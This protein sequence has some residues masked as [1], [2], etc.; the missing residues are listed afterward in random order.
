VQRRR[1]RP[2][3]PE[4]TPTRDAKAPER[5]LSR[6]ADPQAPALPENAGASSES[7]G[8]LSGP[9]PAQATVPVPEVAETEEADVTPTYPFRH[10]IVHRQSRRMRSGET[11]YLDHPVLGVVI[12]ITRNE[13][14]EPPTRPPGE[15]AWRERHSL[16]LDT[17]APRDALD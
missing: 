4:P 10:A 3:R 2:A 9:E 1:E 11:H 14:P 12:R 8:A 5:Q 7:G 15:A 17:V 6:K 13:G 16:P